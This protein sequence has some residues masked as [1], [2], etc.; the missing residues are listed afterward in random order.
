MGG[1]RVIMVGN[2]IQ[3]Q[4]QGQGRD[5]PFGSALGIL[6]MGMFVLTF[7]LRRRERAQ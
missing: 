5:Q 4:F 1:G 2:V 7:L 6:L 3:N